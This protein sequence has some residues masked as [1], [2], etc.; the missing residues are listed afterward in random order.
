VFHS[1]N[2]FNGLTELQHP[3][4]KKRSLFWVT[5]RMLPFPWKWKIRLLNL[6]DS[7]VPAMDFALCLDTM[8][9]H[10]SCS[11]MPLASHSCSR[12]PGKNLSWWFM[13]ATDGGQGHTV[14]LGQTPSCH[15]SH[16]GTDS[17]TDQTANV[18]WAFW[19]KAINLI[20]PTTLW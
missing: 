5:S 9:A 6:N 17:A 8:A 1:C 2:N 18:H 15:Q 14:T 7:F 16:P 4:H 19:W 12:M 3:V 20:L 10:H 11:R 13:S